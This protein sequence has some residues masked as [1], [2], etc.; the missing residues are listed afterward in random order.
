LFRLLNYAAI[1]FLPGSA[2]RWGKITA[3]IRSRF[4]SE[5]AQHFPDFS[6]ILKVSFSGGIIFGLIVLAILWMC[7]KRFFEFAAMQAQ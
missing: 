4:P 6:P 7:R 3:S 1:L 5:M 2:E